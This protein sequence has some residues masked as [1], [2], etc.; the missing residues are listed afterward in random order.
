MVR[1]AG[2]FNSVIFSV[3]VH[4]FAAQNVDDLVGLR[5]G[6]QCISICINFNP[7]TIPENSAEHFRTMLLATYTVFMEANSHLNDT[8][9]SSSRRR[10]AFSKTSNESSYRDLVGSEAK[11]EI[12]QRSLLSH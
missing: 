12:R 8:D 6:T 2:F 5:A 3:Q 7:P 11:I 10:P 9:Y 1:V 4:E